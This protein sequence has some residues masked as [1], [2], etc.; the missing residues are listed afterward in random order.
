MHQVTKH[1]RSRHDLLNIYPHI[2]DSSVHYTHFTIRHI[3]HILSTES[4]EVLAA[5]KQRKNVSFK[6]FTG[7]QE[8][9]CSSLPRHFTFFV[10]RFL[11]AY[12]EHKHRLHLNIRK[13]SCLI[14]NL[15]CTLIIIVISSACLFVLDI[16]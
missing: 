7:S 6:A 13:R 1:H 10:M 8:E 11:F 3:S 16:F 5:G 4:G 2:A 14:I 12:F 15:T 9:I